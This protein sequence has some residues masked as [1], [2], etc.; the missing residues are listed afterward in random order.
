MRSHELIDA[1][2]RA[3]GCAVADA[4]GPPVGRKAMNPSFPSRLISLGTSWPIVPEAFHALR[5]G[6]ERFVAAHALTSAS[7]DVEP[8]TALW[9]L[10]L[11]ELWSRLANDLLPTRPE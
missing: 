9:P 7:A 11:F 6:L 8:G 5:Q 3:S 1:H 4:L 2:S 10:Q